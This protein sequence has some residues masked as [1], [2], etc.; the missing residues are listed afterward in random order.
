MTRFV[1]IIGQ[2]SVYV[3]RLDGSGAALQQAAPLADAHPQAWLAGALAPGARCTVLTDF[4]D[5]AYILSP[6][7]PMW[8]PPARA[9]LLA[10]RLNNQY[11]GVELRAA[12]V[13]G[14]HGLRPPGMASLFSLGQ[15]ETVTLWLDALERHNARVD[16]VWT[17]ASLVVAAYG[18]RS[19]APAL[20]AVQ[21]P[22]GLRQVAVAGGVPVFSRLALPGE[23]GSFD[24]ESACA[25]TQRTAQ[26]L[27]S[28]NWVPAAAQPLDTRLWLQAAHSP[29]LPLPL[30]MDGLLVN[31]VHAS[32]DPYAE[33]LGGLR[34][35][36]AQQQLLP[37][38][39]LQRWQAHQLGRGALVASAI[40]LAA[41]IG[42]GGLTL[43]DILSARAATQGQEAEARQIEERARKEVLLARGDVTQAALAE[44]SVEAWRTL[45]ASQPDQMAALAA[46]S[47]ALA[48]APQLRLT[49]VAWWVP[50]PP[51]D[52]AQGGAP[53]PA[54]TATVPAGCVAPVAA[55]AAPVDPAAAAP[56]AA[57]RPVLAVL[58][59]AG[60]LPPELA[61][62][63]VADI[64][65]RLLQ[66]LQQPGWQVTTSQSAI[67]L[68]PGK[69][70]AGALGLATRRPV[71]FCMELQGA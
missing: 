53:A 59:V 71:E 5:E 15:S 35:L 64:Q 45:I 38:R 36:P 44:A 65:A 10:R 60:E 2:H 47:A 49:R 25:E 41:A 12:I 37:P 3:Y 26:Y 69:P 32:A 61:P 50:E 62:R 67:E 18:R 23:T 24:F 9:Q 31:A 1:L 13:P 52:P 43:F 57:P 54:T 20:L 46:V 4:L 48:T 21:T 66:A 33:A 7:P 19:A 39:K 58:R 56:A 16:G 8:W 17:F 51:A 42:W 22:S 70:M 68:D 6:L 27:F 55:A 30:R 63:A 40:V 28:Q 29:D 11:R 34:R 14:G